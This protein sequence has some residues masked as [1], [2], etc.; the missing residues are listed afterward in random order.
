MLLINLVPLYPPPFIRE[1][2]L[3]IKEGL[4]PLLDTPLGRVGRKEVIKQAVIM[5]YLPYPLYPLPLDK[6]PEATR[7]V[8]GEGEDNFLR[9]AKPLLNSP[10]N[11]PHTKVEVFI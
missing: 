10:S 5:A 2:E 9:G 4:A 8:R 7:L 6:S 1:G 3:I 11:H